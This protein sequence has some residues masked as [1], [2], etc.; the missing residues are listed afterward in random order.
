MKTI[1]MSTSNIID[2]DKIPLV[3]NASTPII[4][5]C[6]VCTLNIKSPLVKINKDAKLLNVCKCYNKKIHLNC[7]NEYNLKHGT[8]CYRCNSNNSNTLKITRSF[9]Y[10][11]LYRF[12]IGCL[13]VSLNM[14]FI[15]GYKHNY[16]GIIIDSRSPL[17]DGSN[18]NCILLGILFIISFVPVVWLHNIIY[19]HELKYEYVNLHHVLTITITNFLM[20]VIGT[21]ITY[22]FTHNIKPN[23]LNWLI[24]WIICSLSFPLFRDLFRD[25]IL[26]GYDYFFPATVI[27]SKTVISEN[28]RL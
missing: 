18:E 4:D 8:Y 16:C 13:V 12:L 28:K 15:Y 9:S 14:F 2:E 20:Q 19:V 23:I 24:G 11:R 3:H 7:V 27:F 5:Q 21:F 26:I 22:L 10:E 17:C 1:E 6:V 25:L